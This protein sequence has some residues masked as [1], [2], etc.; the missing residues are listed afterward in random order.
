V[1]YLSSAK[2]APFISSLG[3]S[4]QGSAHRQTASAESA[5]HSATS[6]CGGADGGTGALNRAFSA[7]S[8]SDQKPGAMP[9]AS[10]GSVKK[11]VCIL[12]D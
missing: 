10:M 9:Q 12:L 5:I 7:C 3:H 6:L 8:L 2:G 1:Q 11:A 4:P